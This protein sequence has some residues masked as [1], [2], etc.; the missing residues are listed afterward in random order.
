[1]EW[2]LDFLLVSL[3]QEYLM[4][5]TKV[6]DFVRAQLITDDEKDALTVTM[7]QISNLSRTITTPYDVFV[8]Y[9]SIDWTDKGEV[10]RLTPELKREMF[11]LM[12]G[13]RTRR[14]LLNQ[15]G[16]VHAIRARFED[17][18]N[19]YS[20]HLEVRHD[21]VPIWWDGFGEDTSSNKQWISKDLAEDHDFAR[22]FA[23][24]V[25]DGQAL[26]GLVT[27]FEEDGILINNPE[28]ED[29]WVFSETGAGELMKLAKVST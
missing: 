14:T 9:S 25:S 8:N 21:D 17:F 23:M 4:P 26:Q 10:I 19:I 5:E 13:D 20:R 15:Y 16:D 6:A 22:I 2:S 3:L 24:W 27:H 11:D 7:R 29:E 1:M 18:I 12:L 28:E